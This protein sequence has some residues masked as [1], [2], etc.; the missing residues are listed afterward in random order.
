MSTTVINAGQG[1][2]SQEGQQGGR[3]ASS[4]QG[5]G[6]G[7]NGA[8]GNNAGGTGRE[9]QGDAGTGNSPAGTE[10]TPTAEDFAKLQKAM[11]TERELRK[12]AEK[13][14]REGLDHKAKREELEAASQ[15]DLEK[16][17]TR[18][19]NEGKTEARTAT[20]AMLIRA[21]ARALAAE[22]RFRSTADIALL[23]LSQVAVTEAGVVDAAA[24]RKALDELAENEPWRLDVENN[25]GDTGKPRPPKP[26]PSQGSGRTQAPSGA[27]RGVAEAERRFG[28]RTT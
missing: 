19:R 9:G 17:V 21:E 24:I 28:K 10:G 23:D 14:A 25:I 20:N 7:Q 4:G 1:T 2:E 27:E 16:A 6:Q 12:D 3:D 11:L 15:S 5:P 8:A 22:A 26:D 18:A 13:R